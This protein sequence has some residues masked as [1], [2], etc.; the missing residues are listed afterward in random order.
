MALQKI[1]CFKKLMDNIHEAQQT[2]LTI[3]KKL[4]ALILLY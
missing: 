3:E 4:L 1:L 2:I